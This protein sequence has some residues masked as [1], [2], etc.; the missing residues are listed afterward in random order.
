MQETKPP[1]LTVI[2]VQALWEVVLDALRWL[3]R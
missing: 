2:F 3:R 1:S